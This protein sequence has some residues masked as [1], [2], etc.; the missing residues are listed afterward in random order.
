MTTSELLL[1]KYRLEQAI[2]SGGMGAVY[3]ARHLGLDQPVAIKFLSPEACGDP[4]LVA[5]F[6]REARVQALLKSPHV[7]QVFDVDKLPDGRPFIVLEFLEGKTLDKVVLETPA[8]PWAERVQWV[9]EACEGLAAAHEAGL[10]HRDIKPGNLMRARVGSQWV[11]KVLDFGIAK[12]DDGADLTGEA[13]IGTLR[14]MAPEQVLDARSV[15][16]A[17]DLWAMGITLFRLLTGRLPFRGDDTATY[18]QGVLRE[19]AAPLRQSFPEA[20]AA[21]EA[22][23]QQV[24]HKDP[25]RRPQSARAWA[26]ALREVLRGQS[27]APRVLAPTEATERDLIP[28]PDAS[29]P[30]RPWRRVVAGALAATTLVAVAVAAVVVATGQPEALPPPARDAPVAPEAAPTTPDAPPRPVV[31]PEVAPTTP[32]DPPR[33]VV[34]PEAAPNERT[35]EPPGEQPPLPRATTTPGGK[36]SG[37]SPTK[38]QKAGGT[39]APRPPVVPV[40]ENPDHL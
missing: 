33:P 23:L 29:G 26:D 4:N 16:P 1:G 21:L 28:V 35:A 17:S 10:V 7:C 13:S 38:A 11:V 31:A 19:D 18:L 20:P 2:G 36:P 22:A 30:A 24:L 14:Y 27:K 25:R 8:P 34:A 6:L 37:G 40:D 32:G 15:G 39:A 3:R 12:L 5:R 9:I